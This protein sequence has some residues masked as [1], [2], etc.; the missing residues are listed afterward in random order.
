MFTDAPPAQAE[1]LGDGCDTPPIWVEVLAKLKWL[2][3]DMSQITDA[4]CAYLA[5]RLRSGALP[6]LER[7]AMDKIPASHA[8]ID[9]VSQARPD[10][11][12]WFSA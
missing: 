3:L 8:A 2:Y 9:A 4:S 10:L 1:V 11:Q 7:L 5:S 6:A 12:V